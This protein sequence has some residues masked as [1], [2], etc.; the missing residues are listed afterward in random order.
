L[1]TVRVAVVGHVEWTRLV[2]VERVPVAGDIVHASVVWEGPAGG[3]AVAAVQLVKLAGSCTFFTALGD[4]HVGSRAHEE[5]ERLGVRMEVA[6]RRARTREAISL[7]DVSGE[8]STITLGDRLQPDGADPLPWSEMADVHAVY[9]AAGDAPALRNARRS[10]VLVATSRELATVAAAGVRIDAL[11]GSSRDPAERY[12]RRLV[13]DPPELLVITD[14]VRGGEFST[15]AGAAGVYDAVEPPG[16][17]VDTYGVGDSFA[18]AL[19]FALGDDASLPAALALAARCGAACVSGCGPF[20]R[21]LRLWSVPAPSR[22]H[23]SS[24]T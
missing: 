10:R 1:S 4:D 6:S 15:R 23:L 20:S 12:D 21:Q 18:A 2:R 16:P 13:P 22:R 17:V 24:M 11:V 7:V 14:G 8:R 3:G 5:L 9:F 19:T